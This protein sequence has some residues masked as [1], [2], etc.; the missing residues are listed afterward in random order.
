MAII[1]PEIDVTNYPMNGN[2]V[3]FW[4]KM[5]TATYD[6]NV[7]V[8]TMTNPADISTFTSLQS[9]SVSGTTYTKYSVPLAN[10]TGAYVVLMVL[11]GSGNVYVDD[12]TFEEMPSCL[13]VTNLTVSATTS[14]SISM[15]RSF[16]QSLTKI[17]SICSYVCSI[18]ERT[19]RSMKRS[20]P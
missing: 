2:R 18:N 9:V 4:A 3:T 19:Q 6:K 20:A 11:K 5:G 12:V 13:E 17:Y 15:L 16:V 10:A 8:G 14:S 1:L 7:Y